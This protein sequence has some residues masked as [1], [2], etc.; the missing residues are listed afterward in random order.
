M[1]YLWK[2]ILKKPS[3]VYIIRKLEIISLCNLTF[4]VSNEFPVVFHNGSNY[5]YHLIIKELANKFEWRFQCLG[6]NT[7][8][9]IFFPFSAP[10]EKEVTK[11]DKD[12]NE[13]VVTISYKIKFFDSARFMAT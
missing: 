2:R 1:L 9:Y 6:E 4:N 7:E 10:I 8:E 13:S 11:I 5:D 12:L 3:K